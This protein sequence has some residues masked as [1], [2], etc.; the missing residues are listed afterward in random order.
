MA[1]CNKPHENDQA[2]I[3]YRGYK[4]GLASSPHTVS[5]KSNNQGSIKLQ[6]K[7]PEILST[8]ELISAVGQIWD[9]ASR[10][11]GLFQP[12][13]N[14]EEI[15]SSRRKQI[16]LSGLDGEALSEDSGNLTFNLRDSDK[17]PTISQPR[18]DL[19]QVSQNMSVFGH[20]SK[21]FYQASFW[22]LL[23]GGTDVPKDS[24]KGNGTASF[25][26]SYQ[27]GSMY[28]WMNDVISSGANR[29]VKVS[30]SENRT[31]QCCSPVDTNAV[32]GGSITGETSRLV[33]DLA[34]NAVSNPAPVKSS[35][36]SKDDDEKSEISTRASLCSDYFLVAGEADDIIS[37]APC[38]SLL[39]DYHIDSSTSCG[40]GLEECL[41]KI[42]DHDLVDNKKKQ[43]EN[44]VITDGCKAQPCALAHDKLH[45]LAKQEH[46]FAG[47]LSGVF[48][49]IC[50][51]PVD[52]IKT[53]IQSCR[54]EQKSIWFIGK[55]IVSDRGLTG[56]YRG[57]A[58]NVASSAPISSIYTFTYE[59]VKGSLLPLFP[60]EYYSVAHC[61][62]GGCASIATSFIFTPSER[63]KQQMQVGSKYHN[64][65]NALV[66]IIQKGG[67]TSLYAGWGAVLCRNV[68]HSIVKFYTYERLKKLMSSSEES[69][70]H[71]STLQTLVCGGLAGST[72]ALFTT[73]FDVV[74]TRLQT[75]IPGSV[76]Q[77]NSVIHAL[78]EIENKEG[79]KGLYRGLTPRLVMYMSQGALFF[80]SYE[81]FKK[82]FS[83]A[84]QQPNAQRI[85]YERNMEDDP[86]TPS[87]FQPPSPTPARLHSLQS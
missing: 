78:Q 53:V 86:V 41:H 16:I 35:N 5:R 31:D 36:L 1:R 65:W 74:K 61:V 37:R 25:E 63:I 47:A 8:T 33:D 79:L 51:H 38:S 81:F 77:Y 70:N 56:L 26:V 72:A 69:R 22:R 11:L 62:A 23:Y 46:A 43:P 42:D 3:K 55:S 67:F 58:T 82:S 13:V 85:Q 73:P 57:I 45:T 32:A 7:S 27:L 14:S 4:I 9:Y 10:P 24:S 75:Q 44:F 64:C 40:N 30:E 15:Q 87:T 84:R 17:I 66:G 28:G 29:P 19:K 21:S 2:S 60:K 12:K 50:L 76:S 6:N 71:P 20:C 52:T 39:A 48:V 83:L 34:R 18:I 80:A 59:S 68:P 54:A 49:S